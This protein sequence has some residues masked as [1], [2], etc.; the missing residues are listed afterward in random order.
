[1]L[2]ANR[3]YETVGFHYRSVNNMTNNK[4]RVVGRPRE[5]DQAV[6]LAGIMGQFWVRG[7]EGTSMSDLVASSGIQK[8]SLYA[9]YGDKQAIYLKSLSLYNKQL[10]SNLGQ[11][12][13][14]IRRPARRR[15][16]DLFR[17]SVERVASG[18]RDGCFLCSAAADRA[19]TDPETAAI[20]QR[21]LLRLERL[22]HS[23][24]D[25]LYA[26]RS[27]QVRAARHL[28]AIYVGLQTLSRAGHPVQSLESIVTEA[29]A[30]IPEGPRPRAH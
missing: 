24:L 6:V 17:G 28:L 3:R 4:T 26:S 8:A 25:G 23:T 18:D 30:T 2:P 12:L 15:F 1:M 5:F 20:V 21:D 22:F 9:A 14:D 27:G 13:G 19:D 7:F 29:L 10:L 11:I 16:G